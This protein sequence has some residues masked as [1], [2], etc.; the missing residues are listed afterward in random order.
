[1]DDSWPCVDPSV[2][3]ER[4]RSWVV[5]L[6]SGEGMEQRREFAAAFVDDDIAENGLLC[7][8]LIAAVLCGLVA[9]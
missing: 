4:G 3:G 5:G 6:E 7:G 8:V 9:E 2:R 1:M